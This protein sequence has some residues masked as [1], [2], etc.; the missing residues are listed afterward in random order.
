MFEYEPEIVER[1]PAL[2][3]GV[4][5][6]EGF[7]NDV[8][9]ATLTADYVAQQQATIATLRD[10]SVGDVGSI[11]AWRRVFASLGVKPTQYRVAVEALMRRLVKSGDIPRINPLVDIGNLVSIRHALLAAI[12]DLSTISAPIRVRFARGDEAFTNL[13][14]GEVDAPEPGEVIFVDTDG[15]VCARRWCWRQSAQAATD[16]ATTAALFVVEAHHHDAAADVVSA[17]VD[18]AALVAAHTSGCVIDYWT[19][20]TDEYPDFNVDRERQ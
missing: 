12:F 19:L 20:P 18:I 11:A 7:A 8:M 2:R 9:S 16:A 15:V 1:Y 10:R 3:A 6:V 14:S 5:S 13:G 17:I 4:V